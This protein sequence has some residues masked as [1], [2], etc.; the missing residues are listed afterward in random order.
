MERCGFLRASAASLIGLRNLPGLL[1]RQSSPA[2]GAQ[3]LR[4]GHP[5]ADPFC[6]KWGDFYYLTGTYSTGQPSQTGRAF[7][8][9]RSRDLEMWESL[10][11]VLASDR[12]IES[13]PLRWQGQ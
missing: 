5:L 2:Q 13:W 12:R 8:L 1:A 11:P 10:G 9:L 3:R 7:D 4:I 6:L